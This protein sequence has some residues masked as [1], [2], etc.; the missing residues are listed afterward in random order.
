MTHEELKQEKE[1]SSCVLNSR[2]IAVSQRN[3]MA[4]CYYIFLSLC[5]ECQQTMFS[6][7]TL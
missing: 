4:H 2:T 5:L 1:S 3:L 7:I 6:Q